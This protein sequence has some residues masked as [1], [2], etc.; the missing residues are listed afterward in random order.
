[1]VIGFFTFALLLAIVACVCC[2]KKKKRPP[3]MHMPYYT[4][5]NGKHTS[6]RDATAWCAR[7][8][9]RREILCS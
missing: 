4:D 9:C 8:A 5:E 7:H 3:H 6:T 2:S 1:M